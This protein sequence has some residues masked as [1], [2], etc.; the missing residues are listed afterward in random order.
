[1]LVIKLDSSMY[2]K[3][4]AGI[5]LIELLISMLIG[6][7][8]MAGVLQMFS[9][10]SQNQ[11]ATSGSSRIQENIRYAFARIEEDLFQAGN[12]GCTNAPSLSRYDR[13][14]DNSRFNNFLGVDSTP[15]TPNSHYDFLNIVYGTTQALDSHP[16]AAVNTDIFRIRYVSHELKIPVESVDAA[17]EFTIDENH[18]D[19]GKIKKGEIVS[20]SNCSAGAI[21]VLTSDPDSNGKV[22]VGTGTTS[23][24]YNTD[25]NL[26]LESSVARSSKNFLY[27]GTTGAYEY[28]I[29][30]SASAEGSETCSATN[31]GVCALYRSTGASTSSEILQGVHDMEVLYGYTDEDGN[32]FYSTTANAV[33]NVNWDWNLVDRMKI[34][35]SFNS[36]ENAQIKGNNING[37]LI[38][39]VTRTFNLYNQL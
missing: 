24:I 22:T 8:I 13:D 11:V 17:N 1:M 27:A 31:Q 38:K 36:I 35:L 18:D 21:F 9:T 2:R 37:L 23:G 28:Y 16:K 33:G 29:G 10:T 20:V 3:Y 4:Q 39:D 14:S 26:Q 6:L 15:V 30:T 7:F 34:T 19:F 25:T 5:G 12:L 32:L